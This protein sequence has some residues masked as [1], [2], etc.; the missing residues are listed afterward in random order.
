[1]GMDMLRKNFFVALFVM[2]VSIPA[3]AHDFSAIVNGQSLYFNIVSKTKRTA[4]VTYGGSI[5]DNTAANFRGQLEIPAQ[6]THKGRNYKVVAVGAKA[7]SGASELKGITLPS[8]LQSIDDFAF[9]GCSSLET[10]IFPGNEMTIGEGAF[11][12]C[13]KISHITFGSDWKRINFKDFRWSDSLKSVVIPAKVEQIKNMKH[14]L[15]LEWVEVD[16]NNNNF[17]AVG[18]VLYN[19][20]K[21]LLYGCPRGYKGIVKVDDST[22]T[23]TPGAFIDCYNV[24]AVEFPESLKKLSFREFSQNGNL[25]YLIFKGELL[26]TAKAE[27]DGSLHFAL[28]LANPDVKIYLSKRCLSQ[29]KRAVAKEEGEYMDVDGEI[30]YFVEKE[31]LCSKRNFSGVKNFRKFEKR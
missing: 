20:S 10:I 17:T 4:E 12:G 30:P 11:F 3:I 22:E 16:Q 26:F 15:S 2:L 24:V 7:F 28:Q 9:E 1:M 21:S 29:F 8:G 19:K 14:Q 6:V 31:Q 5:N 13:D 18:G 25:E 27:S 23:I